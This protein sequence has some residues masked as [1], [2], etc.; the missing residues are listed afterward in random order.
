MYLS[1]IDS[2]FFSGGTSKRFLLFGAD[3]KLISSFIFLK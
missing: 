3:Q 1:L 2:K